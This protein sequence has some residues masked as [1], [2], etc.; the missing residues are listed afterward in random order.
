M[1]TLT[2]TLTADVTIGN[3]E[4][5]VSQ[6]DSITLTADNAV[7]QVI[8]V[9]IASEI[10]V[11]K[12]GANPGAGQL[13]DVSFLIITNLDSTN[14]V[15]LRCKDDAAHAFDVKIDAGKSF[16]MN[17]RKLNVSAT[18]AAFA[19]FSDL[20]TISAQADTGA[21]DIEILAVE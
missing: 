13:T 12:I 18:A 4:Y 6:S 16:I 17:N 8:T 5:K 19:S 11:F 15:R 2:T 21:C 9:P 7:N 10:D 1:A 14:F 3:T 20:D